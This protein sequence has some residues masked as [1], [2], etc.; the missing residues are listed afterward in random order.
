[1]SKIQ[2]GKTLSEQAYE[3]LCQRIQTMLP[4]ENRLPSEEEL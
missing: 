1:M 4:G 2:R 3:V